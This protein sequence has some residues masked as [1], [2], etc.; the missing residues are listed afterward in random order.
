MKLSLPLSFAVVIA[1]ASAF[2]PAQKA[3]VSSKL[4]FLD[5]SS[6]LSR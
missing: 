1:S 4:L 2:A 5:I 6:H 3:F